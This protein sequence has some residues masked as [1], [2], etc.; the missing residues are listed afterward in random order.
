M[1]CAACA[2]DGGTLST[3]SNLQDLPHS[4][5]AALYKIWQN[6][7]AE[8]LLCHRLQHVKEVFCLFF[9]LVICLL[10]LH[11]MPVA[12]QHNITDLIIIGLS[13]ASGC[14]NCRLPQP[15]N[16]HW[17]PTMIIII[18]IMIMP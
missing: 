7:Y 18:I 6:F 8:R 16:C 3:C 4:V 1:A 11:C 17:W 14:A 5:H 13:T 15:W 10:Y 12:F 2:L 9:C